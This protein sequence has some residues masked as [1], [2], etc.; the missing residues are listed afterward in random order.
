MALVAGYFR[1]E[2]ARGYE[3]RYGQNRGGARRACHFQE[4]LG[5]SAKANRVLD[6]SGSF[7]SPLN[8]WLEIE[9]GKASFFIYAESIAYAKWKAYLPSHRIEIAALRADIG[10]EISLRETRETPSV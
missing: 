7:R 2:V 10:S 4:S 3:L 8:Q 1:G 5:A 9:I 6:V